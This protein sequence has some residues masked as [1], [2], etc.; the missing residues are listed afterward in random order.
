MPTLH[1]I[2]ERAHSAADPA[3]IYAMLLDRPNWPTWS[4]LESFEHESDG[5]SGPEKVRQLWLYRYMLESNGRLAA[6]GGRSGQTGRVLSSGRRDDQ[7]KSF[8]FNPGTVHRQGEG[9]NH[10]FSRSH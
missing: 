10:I 6:G 7:L 3:V 2:D 8:C 4:P 5:D 1:H 9:W